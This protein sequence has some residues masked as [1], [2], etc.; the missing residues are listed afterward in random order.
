[1]VRRLCARLGAW[2]PSPFSV[3]WYSRAATCSWTWADQL[4]SVTSVTSGVSPSKRPG[5]PQAE[6][7]KRQE[8]TRQ[9]NAIAF[10]GIPISRR[11]EIQIWISALIGLRSEAI[12][13]GLDARMKPRDGVCRC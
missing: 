10:A 2:T 5:P 3:A 1:C 7:S 9:T 11:T 8:M 13:L 4:A 6:E 12:G